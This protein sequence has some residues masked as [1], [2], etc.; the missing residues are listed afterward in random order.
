MRINGKLRF[1]EQNI[2]IAQLEE[3]ILSALTEK[4][5]NALKDKKQLHF[6]YQY[7]NNYPF[8]ISVF[9]EKNTI[10][11]AIHAIG[12]EI[13]SLEALG[14]PARVSDLILEKAGIIFVTGE[15]NSGKSNTVRSI[16]EHINQTQSKHI[17]MLEYPI[18]YYFKAQKS[19]FSQC[20]LHTDIDS[21][22]EGLGTSVFIDADLIVLDNAYNAEIISTILNLAETGSLIIAQLPTFGASSTLE[23]IINLFPKEKQ[24]YIQNKLSLNLKAILSQKLLP[25][26]D[27]TGQIP[28]FELMLNNDTVKNLIRSGSFAQIKNAIQSGLTE[29]MVSLEYYAQKLIENGYLN[30]D[31][32]SSADNF[33]D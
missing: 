17:F 13:L 3:T 10:S 23:N 25:R 8:R 33:D 12:K 22:Q 14:T 15:R 27:Q 6:T 31:T 21:Y 19:I 26:A 9:Y 16:L 30:A 32:F 4:Q 5:K 2:T 24:T 1:I 18:E 7:K 11:L 28:L 29:G 20:E